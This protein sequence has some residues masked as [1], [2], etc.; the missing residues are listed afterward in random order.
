MVDT[1]YKLVCNS[2]CMYKMCPVSTLQE[3]DIKQYNDLF[4]N[5]IFLESSSN[6]FDLNKLSMY[7]C[8]YRLGV[9][10]HPHFI[11]VNH[12][13]QEI[14]PKN[15]EN[16]TG[17]LDQNNNLVRINYNKNAFDFSNNKSNSQKNLQLIHAAKVIT[18]EIGHS[19]YR[20]TFNDKVHKYYCVDL[21]LRHNMSYVSNFS[22]GALL[23]IFID[24]VIFLV[25]L[26]DDDFF[27]MLMIIL[28]FTIISLILYF[29]TY[30][31][32]EYSRKE[33][34]FADYYAIKHFPNMLH[35]FSDYYK[36]ESSYYD[37][38]S[39]FTSTHPDTTMRALYFEQPDLVLYM[40][41][42][43]VNKIK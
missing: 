36:K 40:Y 19:I 39:R 21:K 22:V 17:Y 9:T 42:D 31:Y 20:K 1:A 32:L 2:H 25:L 3:H 16:F 34:I 10:K 12:T 29:M 30:N 38:F 43:F 15:D 11:S 33:E 37:Y 26:D 27:D 23:G 8:I 24:F 35:Y 14:C 5:N 7:L 13:V 28:Y 41:P 4:D 6:L 18:H